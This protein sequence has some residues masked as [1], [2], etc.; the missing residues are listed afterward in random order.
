MAGD[1]C[2]EKPEAD[3]QVAEAA[4]AREESENEEQ[5]QK[6][7]GPAGKEDAQQP[8]DS[9]EG[10]DKVKRK[11]GCATEV[12]SVLGGSG[13]DDD[14]DLADGDALG[15]ASEAAETR[16]I[17]SSAPP[18]PALSPAKR[19]ADP[20]GDSSPPAKKS[21]QA[22]VE[23]TDDKASDASQD[24]EETKFQT[25]EC[26]ICDTD[27]PLSDFKVGCQC[28]KCDNDDV[29]IILGDLKKKRR[30]FSGIPF[31]I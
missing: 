31:Q 20:C 24:A 9:E 4:E 28:R 16:S 3:H 6:G 11:D 8:Q 26:A 13:L 12:T 27:L 10:K 29:E 30:R 1:G 22:P 7:A 25:K 19:G 18:P 23:T 14:F 21:K 2:D 15:W 17:C 5:E